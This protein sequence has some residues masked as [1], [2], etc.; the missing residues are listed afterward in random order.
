MEEYYDQEA[1]KIH[2]NDA[3]QELLVN[4]VKLETERERM[5]MMLKHTSKWKPKCVKKSNEKSLAYRN[6]GNCVYKKGDFKQSIEFYNKALIYAQIPLKFKRNTIREALLASPSHQQNGE[7]RNGLYNGFEDNAE[8]MLSQYGI[9]RTSSAEMEE[10]ELADSPGSEAVSL[11]YAD[12]E[13]ISLAHSNRS[14]A[15]FRLGHYLEAIRDIERSME[16][17]VPAETK[18]KLIDREQKCWEQLKLKKSQ[19]DLRDNLDTRIE[20]KNPRRPNK[21]DD[22]VVANA[23]FPSIIAKV[24]LESTIEAGRYLV[25]RQDIPV[26]NYYYTATSSQQSPRAGFCHNF[27]KKLSEM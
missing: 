3:F 22:N 26:G 24:E 8:K 15:L 14:A 16:L 21:K 18:T 27:F 6:K 13:C 1:R 2:N 11:K 23:K 7:I 17:G 12:T 5:A 20:T 4:F 9:E 10:E 25:S 19:D